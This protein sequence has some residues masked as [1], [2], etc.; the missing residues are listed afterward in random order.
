MS[1][2]FFAGKCRIGEWVVVDDLESFCCY[3]SKTF[4]IRLHAHSIE[5]AIENLN[6]KNKYTLETC[7]YYL[8]DDYYSSD[9][10]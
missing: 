5:Q 2:T 3:S 8:D 6:Q 9:S 4:F 1:Q 7:D 10:D